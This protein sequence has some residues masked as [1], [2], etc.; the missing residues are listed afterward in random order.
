M[1]I[2][3]DD[4]QFEWE[5]GVMSHLVEYIR[6][7]QKPSTPGKTKSDLPAKPRYTFDEHGER[8]EN[9]KLFTSN[10]GSCNNIF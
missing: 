1:Y 8:K 7:F 4:C 6:L 2:Q 5:A 10:Y 3:V 9:G